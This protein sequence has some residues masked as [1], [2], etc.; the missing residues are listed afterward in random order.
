VREMGHEAA[1]KDEELGDVPVE[2]LE[3]QLAQLETE[4]KALQLE[5]LRQ[6][7]AEGQGQEQNK[8]QDE[9]QDEQ[10]VEQHD[11]DMALELDGERHIGLEG[12]HSQQRARCRDAP[13]QAPPRPG[14]E[15]RGKR[16]S[17]PAH[18]RA[19]APRQV[20]QVPGGQG[21]AGPGN[22]AALKRCAVDIARQ[23]QER[24]IGLVLD[25]VQAV[26]VSVA[27]DLLRRTKEV[28]REGGLPVADGTRR[29]ST[30]GVYF[31]FARETVGHE[32][33]AL[34][35]ARDN[36]RRKAI[37]AHSFIRGRPGAGGARVREPSRDLD[38][39]LPELG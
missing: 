16:V 1:L 7:S 26:G 8:Q 32:A 5:L 22:E 39:H 17:A 25:I 33:Y 37:G 28:E 24:N 10:Q 11:E 9:L 27:L 13:P 12:D 21:A 35:S 15:I 2:D 4:T 14:A 36:R 30:G 31:H 34:I 29:K 3:A 18:A 38:L 23:M 20:G 19:R 6:G